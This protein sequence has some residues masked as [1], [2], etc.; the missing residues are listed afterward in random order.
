VIKA[1]AE[2]PSYIGKILDAMMS[3]GP[4][5]TMAEVKAKFSE[6]AVLGY[7]GAGVIVDK[8]SSRT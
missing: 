6:Y 5:R 3:Q 2:N 4:L 7:S 8:H 1:V